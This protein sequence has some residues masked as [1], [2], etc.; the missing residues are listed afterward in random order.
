MN[1]TT[2]NIDCIIIGSGITGLCG[3]YILGKKGCCVVVLEKQEVV[4]GNGLHALTGINLYG[5]S[6]QTRRNIIDSEVQFKKDIL[7]SGMCQ[8]DR[9]LVDVLVHGVPTAINLLE[10]L[11]IVLTD[12]VNSGGHSVAR[13]HKPAN[14]PTDYRPIGDLLVGQ[15]LSKLKQMPNVSILTG[16][17]AV[18]LIM[19]NE[20]EGDKSV[21]G[22]MYVR[23]NSSAEIALQS[24]TVMLA[25]GG[26]MFDRSGRSLLAEASAAF[27]CLATSTGFHADGSGIRMARNVGA[28]VKG[29]KDV[30]LDP[31]GIINQRN[32]EAM[33]KDLCP[34]LVRSAGAILINQAGKRFCNELD[35]NKKMSEAVLQNCSEH[36]SRLTS[37]M[38]QHVSYLLIN[39]DTLSRIEKDA[40]SV[41]QHPDAGKSFGNMNQFCEE[42]NISP[43]TLKHTFDEYQRCADAGVD[44][45]GKRVFPT[46]TFSLNDMVWVLEVTPVLHHGN[47][48]I[49]VNASSEVLCERPDGSLSILLGLY[50]AGECTGGLHGVERLSGNG[51]LE[52]IVFGLNAGRRA[53]ETS[54]AEPNLSLQSWTPLRLRHCSKVAYLSINGL[55][56][57]SKEGI[58]DTPSDMFEF[59]FELPS[60]RNMFVVPPGGAIAVRACVNGAEIIR[61]YTPT[62]RSC[63]RG[64]VNLFLKALPD[65]GMMSRH[66]AF[67]RPGDTLDFQGPTVFP[68]MKY[69]ANGLKMYPD[70]M[71]MIA[72]GSG[73]SPMIQMISDVLHRGIDCKMILLWGVEGQ[74][75]L[76][77]RSFLDNTQKSHPEQ[78]K[79]VYCVAQTLIAIVA[80]HL[81]LGQIDTGILRHYLL[82]TF[83]PDDDV[84]VI[85]C[86]PPKMSVAMMASL[87][88]MGYNSEKVFSYT[89]DIVEARKNVP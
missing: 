69:A 20:E 59:S 63:D 80:D 24:S 17:Q 62:S 47:G 13:T 55:S 38:E 58:E 50:A 23:S 74:R 12:V 52:S 87:G 15:L 40:A 4:G 68:R 83:G 3:A 35:S 44:E 2:N 45:F 71:V 41:L 21:G 18:R 46:R 86:G 43:S 33:Q 31:C 65:R 84:S 82:P 34:S 66:L 28:I 78:F 6:A 29:L 27:C 67:L 60:S 54:K 79:V 19:Q 7:Y 85:I 36:K 64:H 89:G 73:V 49:Q 75:D 8:N 72:G 57:A 88:A 5:T 70:K 32:P 37:G 48:G 9:K 56:H 26:Y 16:C 77:F 76:V 30:Q 53:A 10:E 14:W 81:H 22:V 11:G 39:L 42:Y 61:H 1:T 25:T 51:L